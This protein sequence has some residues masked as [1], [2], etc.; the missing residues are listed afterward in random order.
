MLNNSMDIICAVDLNGILTEINESSKQC[1]GYLPEEL[2][3]TEILCLLVPEDQ[4]YFKNMMHDLVLGDNN[5]KFKSRFIHKEG[6]VVFFKGAV[7]WDA[8]DKLFF[9]T[10]REFDDEGLGVRGPEESYHYLFFENPY[11]M[12]I[13]DFENL[14]ILECNRKVLEKYGY[15]RDEFLRLTMKDIRPPED[16]P[17]FEEFSRSEESYTQLHPIRRYKKKS[18][19]IMYMHVTSHIIDFRGRR[20]AMI[21]LED[22]TEKVQGEKELTKSQ[23]MVSDYKFALDESSIVAI[24]DSKGTITYVNDYFC[25]ISQ[26][27]REE[28]IG[29]NHR[30]IKS[31]HHDR[32]FFRDLWS[33]IAKGEVWRGEIKNK[34]KDNS[35][36]WV[37]TTIVPF[38]NEKGKPYQFVAV[39]F[40]I[41]ERKKV[42]ENIM[43]KT[44]L[45]SA[46]TEVISTL[47]QYDDWEVALDKSFGIVGE[48]VDVDRVYYF[49]NYYD[50]VTGEGVTSHRLEWSRNTALPQI[51]NPDLQEVPFELFSDFVRP[52]KK[53]KPFSAIIREME[54]GK[55]KDLLQSQDI[56]SILVLP[57]CIKNRFMGFVGFD[58][59]TRERE[60]TADEISF[61]NTLTSKLSSAIEKRN[62][63]LALREALTEKSMILESIGDAFF[64]VDNNWTVTYWNKKAESILGL[65]KDDVLGSNLWETFPKSANEPFYQRY[66][67]AVEEKK[68]VHFE[69]IFSSLNIWLEVSAYPSP[70]GLSVYFKDVSRRKQSEEELKKINKELALSNSDLEQFA[71]VASHDLQEPL[72]MITSFLSQLEKKY[73]GLLDEK[74]KKYIYFASDGAKRMRNIILD[75]LEFSR[76]GRTEEDKEMV[77]IG[78]LLQEAVDLNRKSIKEKQAEIIWDEALPEIY[79]FKS[80]LRQVLHNLINNG[81]KYQAEGVKPIIRIKLEEN[82]KQWKFVV[83]DNGIG[84]DSVYFDKI[85]TLFQ[86]LHRKEEYSGTGVG[87]AICKKIIENLGGEIWVES[88]EGAGSQFCFTL[89]K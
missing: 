17:L 54:D 84:I 74:G 21:H 87:L 24:T 77:N 58:D 43:V 79:T 59:C 6:K 76:I 83:A 78:G 73:E 69:E 18:G 20:A 70:S 25:A 16:V 40:D 10:L 75:L 68:V 64:A 31:G 67:E 9:V 82:P 26:Y 23:K 61:L 1:L 48:A 2:L 15:T 5:R 46:I 62:T 65:K 29:Q 53:N 12:L 57:I 32:E 88:E 13:W 60:W 22:V 80:P 47:F 44:K 33:T 19:E 72:R 41:T 86:R 55:T 11:P 71:F 39:R 28:L 36:Y 14:R 66:L 51:A 63:M 85:F 30:I 34:A 81:L 35:F 45:L 27:S 42:E 56:L 50:P 4:V 8:A 89:P 49:E 3:G 38:L 52:L 37:D 7:R